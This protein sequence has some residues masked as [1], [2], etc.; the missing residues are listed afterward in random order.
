[1]RLHD[2]Y[3]LQLYLKALFFCILAL[4][5]IFFLVD[6]FEKIDDFIDHQA[7][8]RD[9]ALFYL[10]TTP[11]MARLTLP[12]SVMLSTILSLGILA[13]Q[14]EIVA[15]L[16]SGVSMLR[17]TAPILAVAVGVV[18][19]HALLSELAVPRTNGRMLRV[20]RVDIEKRE[21]QD[22]RVRHGFVYRGEGDVHYYA[23]TFNT[24]TRTLRDVTV[25]RYARGR[26]VSHIHA[27][28][29]AWRDGAWEF[30]NGSY[31][32]FSPDSTGTGVVENVQ[33]FARR[34]FP[35]LRET[36]EDLARLGP[37]P[38][39]MNY[40]QLRRHVARLRAAGVEVNDYLVDLDTKI[41]YPLTNLILAILGVGLGASKRKTG[42]LT[43]VGLT[44]SIAFAYLALAEFSAA[45]G[46]NESIPP[47]LAA[48]LGPLLFG[49][50]S[51]GLFARAN[52]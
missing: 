22:A 1:M 45:L 13:R 30:D 20:L 14:N 5:I 11:E 31:R 52:R 4:V 40:L 50:A 34:R 24:R 15:L 19:V 41:S 32:V 48:W 42:L 28:T 37:E 7:R 51:I 47:L 33:H 27:E 2:R 16:S 38:E 49:V 6:L 21:P 46:K 26:I 3:V 29:G 25:Y 35:E 43:G 17:L 36:P 10:Y 23:R 44:I 9:V 12:V 8:I 18:G 39:A